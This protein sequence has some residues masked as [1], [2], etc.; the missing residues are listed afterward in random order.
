MYENITNNS[1]FWQTDITIFRVLWLSHLSDLQCLCFLWLGS[2]WTVF[3]PQVYGDLS[4]S[5]CKTQYKDQNEKHQGAAYGLEPQD[6]SNSE[7]GGL[8]YTPLFPHPCTCCGYAFPQELPLSYPRLLQAL[9]LK[10]FLLS[11]DSVLCTLLLRICSKSLCVPAALLHQ[12]F[13]CLT[14]YFRTNVACFVPDI[15]RPC[16]A[17]GSPVSNPGSPAQD[18]LFLYPALLCLVWKAVPFVPFSSP[19]SSKGLY[20][21]LLS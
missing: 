8:S 7:V 14:C 15:L 18:A 20:A 3:K 11:M 1:K 16:S 6:W 2:L 4:K 21:C 17:T 19:C 13:K 12:L 5:T 9:A 10:Q